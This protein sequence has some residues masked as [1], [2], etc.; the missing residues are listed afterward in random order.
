MQIFCFNN[1][2]QKLV[3]ISDIEIDKY[4]FTV[5]QN[6]HTRDSNSSKQN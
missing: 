5:V 6:I 2:P 4:F 1:N 3:H